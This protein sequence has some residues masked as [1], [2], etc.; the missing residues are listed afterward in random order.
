MRHLGA[1]A[2]L[3]S[4][5]PPG[6][7]SL[8]QTRT[9]RF[10]A[11]GIRSLEVLGVLAKMKVRAGPVRDE[12]LGELAADQYDLLVL[13]APLADRD[14]TMSLNGFTGRILSAAP[15]RTALIVRSHYMAAGGPP[16]IP[17]GRVNLL[18]VA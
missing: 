15:D 5:L 1:E 11:G 2:T 8:S 12:V 13:G 17:A 18:E 14:G 6:S 7:N 16:L 4:V 10:L 3:L 9:E